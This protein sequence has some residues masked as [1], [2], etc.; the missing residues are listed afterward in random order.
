MVTDASFESR[1]RESGAF[2]VTNVV[3]TF[4]VLAS[5]FFKFAVEPDAER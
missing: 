3:H 4:S 2:S 5:R 1:R